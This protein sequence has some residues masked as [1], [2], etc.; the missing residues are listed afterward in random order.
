MDSYGKETDG[1][2]KAFSPLWLL[3]VQ[4]GFCSDQS[5]FDGFIELIKKSYS[6][7]YLKN[8][9]IPEH[10]ISEDIQLSEK[11]LLDQTKINGLLTQFRN[12]GEIRAFKPTDFAKSNWST[13]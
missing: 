8:I 12:T 3:D 4:L 11:A 2:G 5:I 7:D 13:I 10:L 9:G 1:V 6:N